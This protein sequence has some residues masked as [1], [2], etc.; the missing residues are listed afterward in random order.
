MNMDTVDRLRGI[1]DIRQ[2]KYRYLRCIDLRLWDEIGDTLTESATISYGPSVFGKPSQITGR[3]EIIAFFRARLGPGTLSTHTAAQPEITIDGDTAVGTWSLR[4][5]VL[6]TGHRILTVS[7]AF[8]HDHY[9][10]GADAWWRIAR[11]DYLGSHEAILSLDDLP[12][13]KILT[14]FESE[15]S[16][17][18]RADAAAR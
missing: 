1:E 14:A 4:D 5:M 13:L 8:G 15:P 10:R 2:V 11:T 6:A 12:T 17:I 3:A 7:T 18:A 16:G 9:E